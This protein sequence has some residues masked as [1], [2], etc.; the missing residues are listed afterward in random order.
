MAISAALKA[1]YASAPAT[2]RYV[3]TIALSHSLFPAGTYYLTNDNQAW[4]FLLETT[5]RAQVFTPVPFRVILPKIDNKGQ[6]DLSLTIAN[7]GQELIDP[8]EY[9]IG[10]GTEPIVCIYRV[11][12]DQASTLPQNSPPLRLVITGVE[13]TKETVSATATRTDVL[14]RAF[15]YNFYDVTTFPGLRR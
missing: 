12:L 8:L 9:A 6:Q 14:N 3:E 2:Q 1:I 10:K 15:P 4:T 7:I 5:S 13:V 11:Y